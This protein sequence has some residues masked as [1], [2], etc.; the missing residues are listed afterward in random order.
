MDGVDAALVKIKGH[1]LETKIELIEFIAC[2][3]SHLFFR[4]RR[5]DSTR[6]NNAK[7][8]KLTFS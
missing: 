8:Q 6:F 1:G 2:L 4:V 3:I 5:G 7:F